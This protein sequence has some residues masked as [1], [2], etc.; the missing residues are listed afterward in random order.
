MSDLTEQFKWYNQG[1]HDELL[2]HTSTPP[3]DM[4]EFYNAGAKDASIRRAKGGFQN[5]RND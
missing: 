4:I 5:K 3:S 2:G 1:W